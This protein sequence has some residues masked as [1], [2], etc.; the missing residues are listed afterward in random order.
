MTD[1]TD[2]RDRIVMAALPHVVFDGWTEAVLRTAAKDCGLDEGAAELAFMGGPVE[3]VEHLASLAD[4]QMIEELSK[5]DLSEMKIRDRIILAVRV[6]LEHWAE[7]REAMRRS[8]QLFALPQNAPK[9]LVVTGCTVDAMWKAIGDKSTDFSYYTKRVS[10]GAVYMATV[11]YWLDDDSEGQA[12][13]WDFLA[14]RI[15]DVLAGIKARMKATDEI[16]RFLKPLG[17]K[18][19]AG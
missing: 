11:L 19:K 13:T 1:R 2:I 8:T 5:R 16:E 14:R 6:R 18:L 3:A 15:D 4:R 7:E 17:D 9:A 10:L 12:D